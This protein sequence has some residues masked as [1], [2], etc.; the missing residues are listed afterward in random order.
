M[1]CKNC[2]A[3]IPWRSHTCTYC[4]SSISQA[5]YVT[6]QH[7]TGDL[8]RHCP[9]CGSTEYSVLTMQQAP[10][11]F[12]GDSGVMV[13]CDKCKYHTKFHTFN[14]FDIDS[15]SIDRV[16]MDA[17]DEF[18]PNYIPPDRTI[19]YADGRIYAIL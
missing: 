14:P 5:E 7:A 13:Q 10:D 19:L 17:L 9:V 16:I 3:P 6:N 15:A 1:N 18:D 11:V 2:G 8:K 12:I 4:D